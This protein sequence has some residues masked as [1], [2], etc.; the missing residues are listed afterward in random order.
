MPSYILLPIR[1]LLPFNVNTWY[2]LA[3]FPN[4]LPTAACILWIERAFGCKPSSSF[5]SPFSKGRRRSSK[6]PRPSSI[7]RDDHRRREDSSFHSLHSNFIVWFSQ[8][9]DKGTNDEHTGRTQSCT[10]T[11]RKVTHDSFNGYVRSNPRK[12]TLASFSSQRKGFIQQL[13]GSV[14]DASFRR[15]RFFN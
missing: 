9:K 2:H 11:T 10:H 5:F 15:C 13:T 6:A 12:K 8:S 3:R 4:H 7:I 14:A 1:L